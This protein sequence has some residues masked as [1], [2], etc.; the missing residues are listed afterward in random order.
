MAELS[1]TASNLKQIAGTVT[2]ALR[3]HAPRVSAKLI[4]RVYGGSPPTNLTIEQFVLDMADHLDGSSDH[5]AQAA[6][7]V[8]KE[9]AEDKQAS[10]TVQVA[11]GESRSELISQ[12]AYIEGA[13]GAGAAAKLGYAGET[14]EEPESL[15][16]AMRTIEEKLRT[17][18][19]PGPLPGRQ[20][21]ARTG[22]ADILAERRGKLEQ[23]IGEN[24]TEDRQTQ[25]ARSDR[26]RER[27]DWD[28][29]YP[30]VANIGVGLF[31]LAGEEQLAEMVRPTARRR[32][33]QPEDVDVDADEP[34]PTDDVDVDEPVEA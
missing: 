22:L 32:K 2:S 8:L 17:Q 29:D 10:S 19:L 16:E 20:P 23:A 11:L 27:L 5:F 33:G 6:T 13:H 1:Q 7:R 26:E 18:E 3:T 34:R 30:G 28:L 9:V 14:P 31:L 21:V 12:R 4:E 15:I 24:R 25:A